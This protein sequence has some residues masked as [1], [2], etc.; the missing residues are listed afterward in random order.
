MF[1]GQCSANIYCRKSYGRWVISA[2]G[3]WMESRRLSKGG[4]K[5]NLRP[6]TAGPKGTWD[7]GLHL[8]FCQGAINFIIE[9]N[10]CRYTVIIQTYLPPNAFALFY[11]RKINFISAV[12]FVILRNHSEEDGFGIAGL[13]VKDRIVS[14]IDSYCTERRHVYFF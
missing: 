12:R 14:Y 7:A 4:Q 5:S 13:G 3:W 1:M 9:S 6:Q 2:N 8:A 11:S 10:E